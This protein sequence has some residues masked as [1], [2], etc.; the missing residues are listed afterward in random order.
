ME[1]SKRYLNIEE[2]ICIFQF[3]LPI[4]ICSS[5]D[6]SNKNHGN[7]LSTRITFILTESQLHGHFLRFIA[8][9][10]AASL[11]SRT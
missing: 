10:W 5:Y 6:G 8:A 7:F 3:V 2:M 9:F 1:L 11:A 4:S